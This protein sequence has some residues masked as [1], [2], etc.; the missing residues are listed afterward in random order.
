LSETTIASLSSF[1]FCS[2]VLISFTKNTK[3]YS[4]H[5][6]LKSSIY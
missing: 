1:T 6:R 4:I 5:I 3:H 2:N